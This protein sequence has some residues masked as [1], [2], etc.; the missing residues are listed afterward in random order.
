MKICVIHCY[1]WQEKDYSEQPDAIELCQRGKSLNSNNH[2]EN[3]KNL[4]QFDLIST[5]YV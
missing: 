4:T 5:F 3:E 2:T 1:L